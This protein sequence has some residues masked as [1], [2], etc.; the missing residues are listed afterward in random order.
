MEYDQGIF[1]ASFPVRWCDMDSFGHVNNATYFSYLEQ[2]RV[3]WRE[4]LDLYEDYPDQGPVVAHASCDYIRSIYYPATI[5]VNIHGSQPGTSSYHL[6]Y[7]ILVDGVV[8]AK[9][10]TVMVWVDLKTGKPSPIPE[11]LRKLL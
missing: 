3:L 1:A 5:T 7:Q 10:N 11:K 4:S 2:A 8:H 6:D 9:A